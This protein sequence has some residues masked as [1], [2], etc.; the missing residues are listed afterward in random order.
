M[1]LACVFTKIGSTTHQNKSKKDKDTYLQGS[2]QDRG[3]DPK[4]KLH[5]QLTMFDK[6]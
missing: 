3:T 6:K 1:T 2:N 5:K 4:S